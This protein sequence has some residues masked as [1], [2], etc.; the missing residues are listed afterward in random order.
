MVD[1]RFIEDTQKELLEC[2]DSEESFHHL[3][4]KLKRIIRFQVAVFFEIDWKTTSIVPTSF[5]P[6]GKRTVSGLKNI[7]LSLSSSAIDIFSRGWIRLHPADGTSIIPDRALNDLPS[8]VF[9]FPLMVKQ[10]VLCAVGLSGLKYNGEKDLHRLSHLFHLLSPVMEKNMLLDKTVRRNQRLET[11]I[12]LGTETY[13]IVNRGGDII[14]F[15]PGNDNFLGYTTEEVTRKP[16]YLLFPGGSEALKALWKQIGNRNSNIAGL[17]NLTSGKKSLASL[18]VTKVLLKYTLHKE[19][20]LIR[21]ESLEEE[22]QRSIPSISIFGKKPLEHSYAV[23]VHLCTKN[24]Y[25]IRRW[26]EQAQYAGEGKFLVH[27]PMFLEER[28]RQGEGCVSE[29]TSIR[30]DPHTEV[31][32]E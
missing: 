1:K 14:E 13:C 8:P 31:A 25:C 7:S 11:I 16:A 30:N 12:G 24:L 2:F 29:V 22:L 9:L 15:I 10:R 32:R 5:F 4:L 27:T 18:S 21:M 23:R 19:Y 20:Y 28:C 3:A 17:V 6:T 26:G